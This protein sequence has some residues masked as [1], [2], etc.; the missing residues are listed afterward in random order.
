MLSHLPFWATQNWL[1]T[2]NSKG[3]FQDVITDLSRSRSNL[4]KVTR[5]IMKM[6]I[7]RDSEGNSSFCVGSEPAL[8]SKLQIELLL[9]GNWSCSVF[10][11][12]TRSAYVMHLDFSE[13][14]RDIFKHKPITLLFA[15]WWNILLEYIWLKCGRLQSVSEDESTYTYCLFYTPFLKCN[16]SSIRF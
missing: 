1:Q 3:H 10:G 9:H 2:L 13:Q 8:T 15:F 11:T 12:C 4:I 7:A 5:C 14:P 16:P 6:F